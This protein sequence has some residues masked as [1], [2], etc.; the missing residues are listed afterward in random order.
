MKTL[1]YSVFRPYTIG[2]RTYHLECVMRACGNNPDEV[3]PLDYFAYEDLREWLLDNS[4]FF[5]VKIRD[6]SRIEPIRLGVLLEFNVYLKNGE[7]F[8]IEINNEYGE[9]YYLNHMPYAMTHVFGRDIINK[10]FRTH[11]ARLYESYYE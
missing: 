11:I 10:D 5:K 3:E 8:T 6:I 4:E 1:F 9:D 2:S 7:Y